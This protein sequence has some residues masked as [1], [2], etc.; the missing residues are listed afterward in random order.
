MDVSFFENQPYNTQ[1]SLQGEIR[2]EENFWEVSQGK[3]MGEEIGE[4]GGVLEIG[5][6]RGILEN[7]SVGEEKKE[8]SQ[9]K[10]LRRR[11]SALH[12]L[13]EEEEIHILL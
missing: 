11:R 3:E 4:I 6:I 10:K 13:G 5:E 2:G 1:N 7:I 9:K 12:I 8:K